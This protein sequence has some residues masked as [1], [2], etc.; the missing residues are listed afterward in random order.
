VCTPSYNCAPG[1]LWNG[2]SCITTADECASIDGRAAI[3]VNELRGVKARMQDVCGQNP[4]GQ[5][6]EDLKQRQGEALRR[7][8]MLVTEA[9]PRCQ[10][11]LEDVGSL[12]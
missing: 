11:T 7:Y 5:D 9:G 4:P 1:E 6:C 12:E 2:V 10:A 8:Q 3:L